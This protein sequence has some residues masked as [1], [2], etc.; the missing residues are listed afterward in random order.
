MQNVK[1]VVKVVT[2][3]QLVN[4]K[5]TKFRV[6]YPH[7]FEPTEAR[8]DFASKYEV[9]MLFPKSTDMKWLKDAINA[10]AKMG[11]PKGLPKN[12]R[13]PIK[14]GDNMTD[15]DGNEKVD[16]NYKGMWYVKASTNT[17]KKPQVV[18][19]SLNEII[20]ESE[21]YPGCWARASVTIKYYSTKGNNGVGVYLSNIQKLEDDDSFATKRDASNDFEALEDSSQEASSYE[22]NDEFAGL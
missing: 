4:V 6:S 1:P 10:A 17:K 7:I 21:F 2:E 19:R 12:F 5:T 15:A 3:K 13:N 14:D 20:D 18:D 11:F 22:E 8:G 16:E 9:T